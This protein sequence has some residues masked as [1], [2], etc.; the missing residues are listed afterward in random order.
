MQLINHNLS[1]IGFNISN[2][3]KH[4]IHFQW[5]VASIFHNFKKHIHFKDEII[6]KI[7]NTNLRN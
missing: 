2:I 6:P 4:Q 7:I 1:A 5:Q 3:K